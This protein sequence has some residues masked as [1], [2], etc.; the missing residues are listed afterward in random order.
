[1]SKIDFSKMKDEEQEITKEQLASI[2]KLAKKQIKLQKDVIK[3]EDK[4]KEL[5]AELVKTAEVDI[6]SVM[7]E[8]GLNLLRL[9]SGDII[10]IK[11]EAYAN[12][13]EK[14]WPKVMKWLKQHNFDGIVKD[15]IKV[16]LGKGMSKEAERIMKALEK[17]TAKMDGVTPEEKKSIHSGTLKAFV[18]ERI[19]EGKKFPRKL[20]GVYEKDVA[21][22]KLKK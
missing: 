1:V 22:I 18:K 17:T 5:K 3:A 2:S 14:N 16:V 21:K 20:F 4:L 15:E 11:S 6:P 8:V 9:K 10:E 7:N 19:Q 13:S 12:I